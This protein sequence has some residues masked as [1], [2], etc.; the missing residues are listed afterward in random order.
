[1][2][3]EDQ[4]N[5]RM[6]SKRTFQLSVRD[7]PTAF[8][9]SAEQNILV[10]TSSSDI[11]FYKLEDLGS[12]SHI[13]YYEQPVKCKSV[14]VQ[15]GGQGLVSCISD[16]LVS[17][18]DPSRSVKPMID[19]VHPSKGLQ[20]IQW[21][22]HYSETVA[23]SSSAGNLTMWDIRTAMRPTHDLMVSKACGKIAWC[24]SNPNLISSTCEDRYLLVWDIR[25]MPPTSNS[26]APLG[27]VEDQQVH[28]I[29]S[30]EGIVNYAWSPIGTAVYMTTGNCG[31]DVWSLAPCEDDLFD[32][33]RI[34]ASRSSLINSQTKVLPGPYGQRLALLHCRPRT[35][36]STVYL[37]KFQDV[38]LAGSVASTESTY[39]PS[40]D[41]P[42]Q[43]GEKTQQ[44]DPFVKV[45]SSKS[46]ILDMK[47]LN[48]ASDSSIGDSADLDLLLLNED[49]LLQVLHVPSEANKTGANP[50]RTLTPM[51]YFNKRTYAHTGSPRLGN[52]STDLPYQEHKALRLMKQSIGATDRMDSMYSDKNG[53]TS[54]R[55]GNSSGNLLRDRNEFE[56]S[57]SG[58]AKRYSL[59]QK[60]QSNAALSTNPQLQMVGPVTFQN[61]LEDDLIALEYGINHGYL[62]GWRIGRIDPFTRRIF[63]ELLIPNIDSYSIA[64][65]HNNASFNTFYR[66][67][68]LNSFYHQ[69]RT[70]NVR[71]V[72]LAVTFPVKYC[73]FWSPT[74]AIENKSGLAVSYSFFYFSLF[75]CVLYIMLILLLLS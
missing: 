29:E 56:R 30:E 46:R 41:S 75:F 42:G 27:D 53:G 37:R 8:D 19:F 70:A 36:E 7:V 20:D 64:N 47:W 52:S 22:P 62:E 66:S 21:S 72:E 57:L 24:P 15:H 48:S 38:I 39:A 51:S 25:M 35:G 49:A 44:A 14:K 40:I 74:F 31:L 73:S 63:L 45:G 18:W 12:P 61:L 54:S 34:S 26:T 13:I 4:K 67:E 23:T 11:S 59:G 1:M 3:I 68:D 16:S 6:T 32:S 58:P 28:V 10:V 33:S 17:I 2:E 71:F 65:K 55:D 43:E 9:Y 69:K 5:T 60:S 50:A